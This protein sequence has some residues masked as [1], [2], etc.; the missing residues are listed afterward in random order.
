MPTILI[1][2][3]NGFLGCRIAKY[4]KEKFNVIALNHNDLDITNEKNVLQKIIDAKPNFV[5]HC[6]AISNPSVAA[7]NPL[8]AQMVNV[9]GTLNI[10]KA[11]KTLG[12]KL[13][14]M[15]SD[16]VYNGT[17]QKGL[18]KENVT[19]S[20]TDVYGQNKL[21]TEQK[22]FELLHSAVG[23]RLTWMYDLPESENVNTNIMTLLKQAYENNQTIKVST[24]EFR[25]FTDVRE[26]VK[27]IEKCF[28]IEGGAYNFGSESALNCYESFCLMAQKMN[29]QKFQDWIL[30]D[31]TAQFCNISIC[32]EKIRKCGINFPIIS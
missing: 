22:V 21:E 30:P 8:L 9:E 20:P 29:L 4:Y 10:A 15:S 6:A 12:C 23:L 25:A 3:A 24:N 17:K 27:N 28:T 18:H 1:T 16:Q 14:F 13:I 26:V 32:T 7:Q 11:C 2:G 31:E 5:I 19:L